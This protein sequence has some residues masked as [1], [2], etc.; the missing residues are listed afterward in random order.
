MNPG[1]RRSSRIPTKSSTYISMAT[2][3][4]R[5]YPGE[6]IKKFPDILDP[7]LTLICFA[8]G[9]VLSP[10]GFGPPEAVRLR[11]AG[12]IFLR[13]RGRGFPHTWPASP[14]HFRMTNPLGATWIIFQSCHTSWL[15]QPKAHCVL[16]A[17]TVAPTAR[18]TVLHCSPYTCH[19]PS[20]SFHHGHQQHYQQHLH[21]QPYDPR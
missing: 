18:P 13:S 12:G 10:G 6:W 4:Y 11:D 7:A 5:T 2:F 3:G 19:Q 20:P 8:A 9:F 14:P 17:S 16:L 1:S 21:Q 15:V